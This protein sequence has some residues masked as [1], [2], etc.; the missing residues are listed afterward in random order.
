MNPFNHLL[1]AR[2]PKE[3]DLENNPG[4]NTIVSNLGFGS[5]STEGFNIDELT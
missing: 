2:S 1:H 3:M 5:K 4:M